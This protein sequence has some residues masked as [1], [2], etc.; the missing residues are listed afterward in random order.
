MYPCLEVSARR[1][2]GGR[3]VGEERK[4]REESKGSALRQGE[5]ARRRGGRASN[6]VGGKR[7]VSTEEAK[8]FVAPH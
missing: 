4:G 1:Q 8:T 7:G 6:S 2:E 5:G 3:G